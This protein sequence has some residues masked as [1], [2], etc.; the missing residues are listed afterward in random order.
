MSIMQEVGPLDN[1][2]SMDELRYLR[3]CIRH[4]QGIRKSPPV[5]SQYG[6][7]LERAKELRRLSQTFMRKQD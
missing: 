3:Q 1:G 6:I 4:E 7:T 2:D 5:R